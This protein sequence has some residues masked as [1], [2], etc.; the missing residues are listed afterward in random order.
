MPTTVGITIAA[1]L[2]TVGGVELV[3]VGHF[4]QRHPSQVATGTPST[5]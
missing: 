2:A 3:L 1:M 5:S 4:L